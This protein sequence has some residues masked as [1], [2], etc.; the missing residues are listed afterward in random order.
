VHAE[1]GRAVEVKVL[2]LRIGMPSVLARPFQLLD[3]VRNLELFRYG[4]RLADSLNPN[5]APSGTPTVA[6]A[7]EASRLAWRSPANMVETTYVIWSRSRGWSHE[8]A[9]WSPRSRISRGHRCE[10]GR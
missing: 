4:E 5:A 10:I 9:A 8:A 1:Q 3:R 7:N 6:P 2:R